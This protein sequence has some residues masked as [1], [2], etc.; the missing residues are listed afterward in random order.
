VNRELDPAQ[1]GRRFKMKRSV[2]KH[3]GGEPLIVIHS[4]QLE[5]CDGNGAAAA[6]LSHLEYWHCIK[7]E[8]SIKAQQ[9]NEVAQSHQRVD[10]ETLWQFHS[11][12]DLEAGLLI[13]R[14][15]AISAAIKE[16]VKKG[17]IRTGRNPNPRY[18][19]DKTTF[20][21]FTAEPVNRWLA[22]YSKPENRSSENRP[23]STGSR[24]RQFENGSRAIENGEAIP[25]TS[26]EV[27]PETNSEV[28]GN[29][30]SSEVKNTSDKESFPDRSTSAVFKEKEEPK[31]GKWP[32]SEPAAKLAC[33]LRSCILKNNPEAQVADR[34]VVKWARV[35]DLMMRIDHRS[36]EQIH[37]LILWSQRNEFWRSN[38]LSMGKLRE[39]FDQLT[40][41]KD[42]VSGNGNANRA[43]QR[44]AA[45]LNALAQAKN[46]LRGLDHG[47]IDGAGRNL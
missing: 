4:W 46:S 34:Q 27:T 33:E 13:Y 10:E 5:A 24:S 40:L 20:F 30:S 9:T 8:K 43:Q 29:P 23:P 17:F 45:N 38:I 39:K 12:E 44:Q 14:R 42:E 41:K 35:A 37:D 7:L 16:L 36:F 1:S 21:L 28:K 26:S 11:L 32:P 3:P 6:L 47:A 25:E 15:T 31:S 2:V 18:R 19:F 22:E